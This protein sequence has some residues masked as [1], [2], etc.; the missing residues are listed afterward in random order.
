MNW[1]KL[2]VELGTA[3]VEAGVVNWRN[4]FVGLGIAIMALCFLQVLF[5]ACPILLYWLLFVFGGVWRAVW[6]G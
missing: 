3:F 5:C 2:F 1:Q 6:T 4:L